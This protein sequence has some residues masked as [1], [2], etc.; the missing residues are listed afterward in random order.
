[1]PTHELPSQA[2]DEIK[3]MI[4]DLR[5]YID[6]LING[7]TT[8]GVFTPGVMPTLQDHARR[9]AQLEQGGNYWKERAVNFLLAIATAVGVTYAVSH[10]G[11]KH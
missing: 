7:F 3:A 4:A 8:N 2:A 1:M 10:F 9:I 11:G 5:V 6:R